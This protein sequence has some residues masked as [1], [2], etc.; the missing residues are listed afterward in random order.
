MSVGVDKSDLFDCWIQKMD[1][2]C[3]QDDTTTEKSASLAVRK[4]GLT[5]ML[6]ESW[7]SLSKFEYNTRY[8]LPQ[9]FDSFGDNREQ[10]PYE[11]CDQDDEKSRYS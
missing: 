8:S 4:S 9:V 1:D 6:M 10:R 3:R 11:G 7:H 2:G 5:W